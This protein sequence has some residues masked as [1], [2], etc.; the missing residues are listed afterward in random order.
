[1]R[2]RRDAGL[3]ASAF[4]LAVRRLVLERFPDCAANIGDMRFSPGAF[5]I[6][7]GEVMVSLEYRAADSG[8]FDHL[9]TSLLA[10]AYREAQSYGLE[11]VIEPLGR[12]EPAPMH[13]VVQQAIRQAA[14]RL[15]LS[16]VDLPSGAGHDGQNLAALCPTGMVFI[17]SV[18]GVSHSPQEFSRWE[19]C[20]NGANVL[21]QATLHWPDGT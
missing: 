6:V 3:G 10:E 4:A 15:G 2:S 8:T 19:D 5:N 11:L 16:H 12:H 7:P 18:D 13:P 21:L 9:E 14:D 20:L 1:M 17:P